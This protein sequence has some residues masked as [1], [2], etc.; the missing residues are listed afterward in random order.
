MLLNLFKVIVLD[1]ELEHMLQMK[2]LQLA[3][4]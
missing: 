4:R 3:D 2:G 1:S